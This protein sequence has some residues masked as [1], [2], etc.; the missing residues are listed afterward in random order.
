MRTRNILAALLLMVAGLQTTW[1]QGFRVYK[2]D[3]TVLQFSL[4]TD[5][6]VFYD[7]IGSDVDFGPYTP[8]NQCIDGT[9]YKSET[10]MVTFRENGTT[11]YIEGAT[12][13]FFPYQGNIV[14]YNAS[15]TPVN[16]LRV[17][18]VTADEMIV[19]PLDGSS[20]SVWSRNK[21]V[22]LVTLIFLSDASISLQVNETKTLTATIIP[23]NADNKEVTWESSDVAVAT[24]SNEGLITAVAAGNCTITCSATDGSGVKAECPLTVLKN[25]CP[26]NNHPHAIDLGLPSGT[27]WCCCN[28]GTSTPDRY[29]G[30]YAWGETSE[31][32]V[33][34]VYNW[35][36]YAY[37][38]SNT[39][40]INIGSDIAGTSYDAA[41][42][43]MG[44]PWRM[45]SLAQIKELKNSCSHQWTQQ[46]GVKGILVTGRN[47]GQIFLPAA[48]FRWGDELGCPGCNGGY[49]SSSLYPGYNS[50]AYCILFNSDIWGWNNYYRYYV[51]SVRAVCP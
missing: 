22:V 12:Y 11:D 44:A 16:I 34:N 18:E 25:I 1:A 21:R 7:G 36:T 3:G 41:T 42:V 17:Y 6:I 45:P 5:S 14:L 35:D 37:Y 28:V 15:K 38:N 31:K 39:G 32:S 51:Q 23:D 49:W 20:I 46:N 30:Y 50:S 29:G 33:Y 10:E 48:G 26:D 4:R 19:S 40:I 13:K 8:V 9:W 2:S 27:K 43:N 47:G 24:V